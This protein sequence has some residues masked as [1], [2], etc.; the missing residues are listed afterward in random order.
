M[1]RISKA[2]PYDPAHSLKSRDDETEA[3][4]AAELVCP[5]S[6]WNAMVKSSLPGATGIKC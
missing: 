4:L 6:E 1:L 2:A 3:A 5:I